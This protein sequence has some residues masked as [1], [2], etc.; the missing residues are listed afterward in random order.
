MERGVF[1][2][3]KER[4]SNDTI[5]SFMLEQRRRDKDYYRF[6]SNYA[7]VNGKLGP[8]AN[9]AWRDYVDANPITIRD[10]KGAIILNPNR[11]TA[12]QFYSMPITRYDAQ[13]R[14]IQ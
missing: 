12:E 7:A 14:P 13:G 2:S 10:S 3:E 8:T 4:S 9:R 6:M 1:G 11:V 5:I